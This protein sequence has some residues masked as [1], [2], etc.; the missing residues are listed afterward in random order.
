MDIITQRKHSKT[1]PE[2]DRRNSG[3]KIDPSMKDKLGK[4]DAKISIMKKSTTSV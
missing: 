4:I 3:M 2:R 1:K